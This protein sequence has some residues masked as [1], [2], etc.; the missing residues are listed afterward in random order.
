MKEETGKMVKFSS[1]IIRPFPKTSTVSKVNR[2]NC[3]V[4]HLN[5][6]RKIYNIFMLI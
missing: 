1:L 5:R 3:N 2:E 4:L 6:K